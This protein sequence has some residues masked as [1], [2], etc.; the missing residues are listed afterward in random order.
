MK[1]TTGCVAQIVLVL[2]LACLAAVPLACVATATAPIHSPQLA[3]K[4]GCP[5]NTHMKTEWYQASYDRPGEQSLS[6][7]CVDA[8]GNETSTLPLD[9]KALLTGIWV[10]FPY[11]FVPV[12]VVGAAILVALNLA[13]VAISSLWKKLMRSRENSRG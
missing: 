7:T 4:F 12:L 13:G 8:Q 2:T 3:E 5:P 11:L 9:G 10:Y 6:V 1:K